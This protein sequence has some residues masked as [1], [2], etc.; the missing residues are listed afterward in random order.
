M[1]LTA[2]IWHSTTL[3]HCSKCCCHYYYHYY[4]IRL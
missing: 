4:H 3:A 2:E 1:Q